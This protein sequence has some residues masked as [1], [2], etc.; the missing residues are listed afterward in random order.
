MY[1]NLPKVDPNNLL[2]NVLN[3]AYAVAGTV[4]V[5][6]IIYAGITMATSAGDAAKVKKAKSM[7]IGAVVG[8]IIVLLAA[9]ITNFVIS[10]V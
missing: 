9:A 5:A 2:T 4:V 7:L 1:D 3:A 6:M 10:A 8:L